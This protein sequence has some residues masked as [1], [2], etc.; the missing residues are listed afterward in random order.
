MNIRKI[1]LEE[2]AKILSEDSGNV[3]GWVVE[4]K[5]ISNG[6]YKF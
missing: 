2:V 4:P 1:I 3:K 5:K 6:V